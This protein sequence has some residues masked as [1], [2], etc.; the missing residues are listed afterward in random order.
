MRIEDLLQGPSGL[1]RH[2]TK[3]QMNPLT[4]EDA[5]LEA[6][7][8]E[9]R[10]D[11]L[12]LTLALLL[13]LRMALQ[14]REG[15]T[16]VLIT[17]GVQRWSWEA[18]PRPTARTAWNI[19]GSTPAVDGGLF[20]LSLEM[21]PYAKLDLVAESASFFEGDASGLGE[22]PPDYSDED[23]T[24]RAELADWSSPFDPANAAFLNVT[25]SNV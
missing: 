12:R 1:Q 10:F 21:L 9:V 8:L 15:N 20:V 23:A 18:H 19:V 13:E 4:D 11:A 7:L 2:T 16:G 5:L 17:R 14:L 6:Q 25:S 22:T 3:P 24:V